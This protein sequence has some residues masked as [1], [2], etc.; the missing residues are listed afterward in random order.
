M[1]PDTV[2]KAAA[3]AETVRTAAH[4]GAFKKAV[5]GF[6]QVLAAVP[7]YAPAMFSDQAVGALLELS[8]QVIEQIEQRINTQQD[9]ASVQQDIVEAVYDIRRELENIDTWRRHYRGT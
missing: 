3:F 1:E 6:V 2:A 7:D 8:E 9:G 4:S 5:D